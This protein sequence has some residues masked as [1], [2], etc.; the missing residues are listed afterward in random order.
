MSPIERR[1]ALIQALRAL[2]PDHF[3]WKFTTVSD[4][5]SCGTV[6]CALGLALVMWPEHGVFETE[7]FFDLSI[8]QVNEVFYGCD[9]SY[10]S[11]A[12]HIT[13]AMVADALEATL[14]D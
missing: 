2:M 6:G 3:K 12:N 10:P 14:N 8:K 5:H 13:P 9:K 1:K 7:D 4:Q 11:D